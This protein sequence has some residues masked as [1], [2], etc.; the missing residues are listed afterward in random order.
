M[1]RK[2]ILIFTLFILALP[3][4]AWGATRYVDNTTTSC[5]VPT[6]TDYDPATETCGGGGTSIVHSTLTAAEAAASASDVI[7]VRAGTYDE[8]VTINVASLTIQNYN[9]EVVTFDA[10]DAAPSPDDGYGQ[11]LLV[12][13]NSVI[14]DGLIIQESKG[15]GIDVRD[16]T[17]AIVRNCTIKNNWRTGLE[18]YKTGTYLTVENCIFDS[19]SRRRYWFI[20]YGTY[21]SPWPPQV[22]IDGDYSVVKKCV[23]KD[24]WFEGI[25]IARD[26]TGVIVEENKIYGNARL[27]LY[28]QN[29]DYAVVRY[30]LIYGTNPNANAI[31]GTG[32]AG[33]VLS[34]ETSDTSNDYNQIYGNLVMNTG[35]NM[36]IGGASASTPLDYTKIYN[37]TFVYGIDY[38]VKLMSTAGTNNEFYNNYIIGNDTTN[39]TNSDA[40]SGKFAVIRNNLWVPGQPPDSDF[41]NATYDLT[42]EA[43]KISKKTGWALTD[44]ATLDASDFA[45]DADATAIDAGYAAVG[46]NSNVIDSD[47][48][49]TNFNS[50]PIFVKLLSQEDNGAGWEIGGVG[51]ENQTPP[52]PVAGTIEWDSVASTTG[53]NLAINTSF[54]VSH[55]LGKASGNNRTVIVAVGWGDFAETFTVKANYPT[56][57]GTAMTLIDVQSTDDKYNM[58]LYKIIDAALPAAAGSYDVAVQFVGDAGPVQSVGLGVMSIYNTDQTDQPEATDK[59][60]DTGGAVSNTLTTITNG[61]WIVGALYNTYQTGITFTTGT[62]RFE[63]GTGQDQMGGSTLLVPTAGEASL[64][65]S[66]TGPQCAVSAAFGGAD[67]AP[68]VTGKGLLI[69]G[70][71]EENYTLAI[72]TAQTITVCLKLSENVEIIDSNIIYPMTAWH[73]NTTINGQYL[74]KTTISETTVLLIDYVLTAGMRITNPQMTALTGGSIIDGNGNAIDSSGSAGDLDGTGAISWAIPY[75]STNPLT[76]GE[77]SGTDEESNPIT[78]NGTYATLT[79][80]KAAMTIVDGDNFLIGAATEGAA[81]D[82]SGDDC[83]ELLPCAITLEGTWTQSGAGLTLGD[84]WIITSAHQLISGTVKPDHGGVFTGTEFSAVSLANLGAAQISTFTACLFNQSRATVDATSGGGTVTYPGSKFGR[85]GW[86]Y[87]GVG[88]MGTGMR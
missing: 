39:L 85:T 43:P 25:D 41:W 1:V 28:L 78:W 59:D 69:E 30:N 44:P 32:Y 72:S 62:E 10:N 17:G 79:A 71:C 77:F 11:I 42:A 38:D 47:A 33:I 68:T 66:A 57:N 65:W 80:V 29:C 3:G 67:V 52:D 15:E 61:A 73:D 82:M 2:L 14:I 34:S 63:F 60:S 20:T 56:Y 81:V 18:N 83:T 58:A 23:I 19:N 9:E 31:D 13:A 75:P 46:A 54:T 51:Y 55:A 22:R 88:G 40:P 12:S 24:G 86:I 45:L 5:S 27:Q 26:S 74:R 35:V 50:N 70:V 7:Y 4:L 49:D 53:L 21:T 37:N 48:A 6:D 36:Y 8:Y 87:P 16:C 64:T 84:W 76:I